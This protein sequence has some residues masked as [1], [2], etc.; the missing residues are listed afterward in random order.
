MIQLNISQLLVAFYKFFDREKVKTCIFI[1]KWLCHMLLMTSL[2][3]AIATDSPQTLP[4]CVSRINKQF[5]GTAC[6]IH[7]LA[8]LYVRGFSNF[9]SSMDARYLL[10]KL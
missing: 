4:K 6:G 2:L 3:V 1:Q 9:K 7:P 5:L 8:R 10:L